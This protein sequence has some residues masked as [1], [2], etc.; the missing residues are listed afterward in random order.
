MTLHLATTDSIADQDFIK[1]TLKNR[2]FFCFFPPVMEAQFVEKRVE[3]S[4]YY[5]RSGQ[6]LLLAMF[7][8]IV[9][10]A[11]L[12]FRDILLANNFYL[13][14][15]IQ[16]PIGFSILF[17]I[18]G[19]QIASVRKHFHRVMF[20]VAAFQIISLHLHI[21]LTIET[22]YYIYAIANQMISMLLIA[23]GLRFT[24]KILLF[25]YVLGGLTGGILGYLLHLPVD[26]LAF[27]YYFVLFG[28]VIIALAG[29]S[30]RQ[31]RFAFLQELLVSYQSQELASLNQQLDKIAHEDA[32]T[33][34]ANR[35]SFNNA[36]AR[37]W[38]IA[39]REQRPLS[40]LL[41][42]VDFFKRYND[43]YGHEAGDKCLQLIARAISEA[44]MRPADLAA[45]YGGEE[46]VVLVPDTD[47]RGAI[48]V[49]ERILQAVDECQIAHAS[50]T[51]AAHVTVS[52]G[53]TTLT[54]TMAQSAQDAI[55]Q[56]DTALYQAKNNG[57]HQYCCYER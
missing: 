31:E 16:I 4:L 24:T 27:N 33:G 11:W 53:I 12:F 3:S 42:D 18:Y 50:S 34:I 13:L 29:I 56:A 9:V 45:R 49:A 51:V 7:M 38:D 30:E 54:P 43:T 46:F 5:I 47:M 44:M 20:P 48:M 1:Q 39:L 32:L 14:K 40:L 41:M 23:L 21:F 6:W 35:R 37:E 28:I 26:L 22:S 55:R 17:I 8:A 52:I 2:P 15:F 57:R 10:V 36:A 25:L 19:H